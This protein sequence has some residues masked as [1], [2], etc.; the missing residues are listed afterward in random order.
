[1]LR[2][3]F[4]VFGATALLLSTTLATANPVKIDYQKPAQE[5]ID[6]VD[7]APSPGGS[8]S[9]DGKTL[10]VTDYPALPEIADLA[11]SEYKLAG[12]RINPANFTVSQARYINNFRLVDIAS[13][14]SKAITGLPNDL[15]AIGLA[16]APNGN[17]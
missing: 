7:A 12:R 9:P 15:K 13:G 10:L 5:I 8:L 6:I 1:M 16:W 3:T 11:V 14:D 4:A 17:G 2:S